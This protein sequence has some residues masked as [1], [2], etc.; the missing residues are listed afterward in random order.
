MLRDA[1]VTGSPATLV[2]AALVELGLP[3]AEATVIS[4]AAGTFASGLY[5]AVRARWPWLLA[6]DA[7]SGGAK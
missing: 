2:M 3:T 4:L 1:A 7:P 6:A 5:R